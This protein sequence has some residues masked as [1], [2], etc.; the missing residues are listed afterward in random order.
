M[1]NAIRGEMDLALANFW[2]DQKKSGVSQS[3]FVLS[4]IDV[5]AM[6]ADEQQLRTV[7]T[8]REDYASVAHEVRDCM[9]SA[10]VFKQ[11]FA[12]ATDVVG[13]AVFLERMDDVTSA[14]L[15]DG[16]VQDAYDDFKD[17]RC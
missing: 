6:F 9:N 7:A 4:H 11:M 3:A 8:A 14:V 16:V 1:W 2:A 15:Y 17:Q 10:H 5:L 12:A 13:Y